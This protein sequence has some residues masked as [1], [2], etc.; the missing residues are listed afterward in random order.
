MYSRESLAPL[1]KARA[2]KQLGDLI[3]ESPSHD[4]AKALQFHQ[5][6]IAIALPLASSPQRDLRAA[7]KT[8]LIES[9]TAVATDIAQGNWKKKVKSVPQWMDRGDA[10]ANDYVETEGASPK[11]HFD[12]L[13]RRLAAYAWLEGAADPVNYVAQLQDITAKL[14]SN[15]ED[16]TFRRHVD[17]QFGKAMVDAVDIERARGNPHKAIEYGKIAS[18]RLTPLGQEDWQV[19]RIQ[20]QLSRMHFLLGSIQATQLEDH[21]AAVG[22]FDKALDE[23]ARPEPDV[24]LARC[25]RR[26]EWL[27]S[28]GVS[29]W[30]VERRDDAL[31]LTKLGVRLIEAAE[32]AGVVPSDAL[33]APYNN[34]AVM[35]KE[36]GNETDAQEYSEMATK[37]EATQQR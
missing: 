28:M 25:A 26:G 9:H 6:A 33:A 24:D 21:A 19:E 22:W 23:V 5:Q 31:R 36:L 12:V 14:T 30:N 4:F 10:L 3:A 16:P 11:V 29:Y 32:S 27:V 37:L 15:T 7:A 8:I 2:A 1:V 18:E 13:C 34:L 17:W 20:F 35:H